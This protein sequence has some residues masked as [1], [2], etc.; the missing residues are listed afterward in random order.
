MPATES[1]T[2]QQLIA[3]QTL[4]LGQSQGVAA[5][6]AGVTRMTV[7]RWLRKPIF[8]RK[9][10]EFKR[11]IE[12]IEGESF[13]EAAQ[14]VGETIRENVKKIL[15]PDELKAMLSDMAQDEDL[16][17]TLRLKAATQLG[18]WH[19]MEAK[20]AAP[21]TQAGDEFPIHDLGEAQDIEGLSDK[22]LQELYLKTLA[23][24]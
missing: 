2:Q 16:S 21:T 15:T 12:E 18:K 19:G 6:R 20:A 4:A 23:E 17:P 14:E 1:L 24:C 5:E 3:A 13:R 22:E 8:K 7:S 10:D 9:V 11:E